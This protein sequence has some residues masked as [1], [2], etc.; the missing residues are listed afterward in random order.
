[1]ATSPDFNVEPISPAHVPAAVDLVRETLAEFGLV[2]GVGTDTDAQLPGLPASYRDHGGE[3]FVALQDGAVTG[4]AGVIPV[5]DGVLELRKLYLRPKARR[6]GVGQAL[7]DACTTF[8]RAQRARMLVLDTRED[9]PAAIAF[10]ERNGF[11][12]DDAQLRGSRSTRGYRKDLVPFPSSLCHGC[13][14]PPRYVETK[15]SAFIFCPRL[16]QK[17]PPQPVTRCEAFAPAK[18][19]FR[20]GAS[21]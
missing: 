7:L 21:P 14:A 12:R 9:M 1:M 10:Y 15:T 4:T 20:G 17:Y 6:R 13:D 11:V 19:P 18:P 8:A 16:P 2:F 3:F 5:G